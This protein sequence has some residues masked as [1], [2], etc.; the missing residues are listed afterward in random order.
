M[1]TKTLLTK[2]LSIFRPSIRNFR[3]ILRNPLTQP[4]VTISET[5]KEAQKDLP[6]W[7]RIFDHRK[8]MEH[9]G[10]LKISTGLAMLDVEPF[11]RLKLMKLYYMALEEI[12]DLPDAYKY[13]VVS[14]ELT[15]FRME[16]VDQNKSIKKI[17]ELIGYGM[18]EELI[19]AAH[20]EL[21]LLK[22]VKRWKPWEEYGDYDDKQFDEELSNMNS[23]H[24]FAEPSE[25]YMHERHDKPER[26]ATSG[27]GKDE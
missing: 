21:K 17:E 9:E 2:N 10:P 6:V 5:E 12:R 16:I 25:T 22:I 19:F 27:S 11:P 24:W 20:N 8:Y 14:E 15:K 4:E 1:F 18:V 23:D 3:Y 26:P 7:D 13:K